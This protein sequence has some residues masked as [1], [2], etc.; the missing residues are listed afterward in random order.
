MQQVGKRRADMSLFPFWLAALVLAMTTG[1]GTKHSTYRADE[2]LIANFQAHKAEFNSLLEMFRADKGLI[3]FSRE[4][5]IPESPQS[6]GIG[7]ER[8]EQYRR[9]FSTVGL[10]GMATADRSTGARD[11][12]WFFTSI[13]GARP[14]TF[15]HYAFVSQPKRGVIQDLVACIRKVASGRARAIDG[16]N[17]LR[18]YRLLANSLL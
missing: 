15:K 1:C 8:L 13:E 2:V 12:I 11:E 4:H 3:Y 9:L 7:P 10:D 16:V 14:S 18:F 17:G 5:T 6:V